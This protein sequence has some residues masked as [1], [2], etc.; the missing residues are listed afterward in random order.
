MSSCL[1]SSQAYLRI[2]SKTLRADSLTVNV[3]YTRGHRQSRTRRSCTLELHNISS[4]FEVN[5]SK[6]AMELATSLGDYE[7]CVLEPQQFIPQ[8]CESPLER[9]WCTSLHAT[10]V[11]HPRRLLRYRKIHRVDSRAVAFP[12]LFLGVEDALQITS[13][14]I[15]ENLVGV[16]RLLPS[17][18]SFQSFRNLS[19]LC[20]CRCGRSDGCN[21]RHKRRWGISTSTHVELRTDRHVTRG[22]KWWLIDTANVKIQPTH[23][24][25]KIV[26]YGDMIRPRDEL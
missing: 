23:P 11:A 7:Y 2:R 9:C 25:T 10:I 14:E 21:A 15:H 24:A 3:D 16:H 4:R 20:P 26:S 6:S 8:I 5:V 13:V 1:L 18:L 17:V 22:I 19:V 12:F